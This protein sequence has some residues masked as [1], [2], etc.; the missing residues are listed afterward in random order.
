MTTKKIG[1]VRQHSR[2]GSRTWRDVRARLL[3]MRWAAPLIALVGLAVCGPN[4]KAKKPPT[5]PAKTISGAVLDEANNGIPGASVVLT[6]VEAHKADALYTGAHGAYVFSGLNPN[7]DYQIQA[8]YR[9]LMSEVRHVSSLDSR[10]DVV[11]N[12]VVSSAHPAA[13]HSF[14]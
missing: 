10:P 14:R 2:N 3:R 1:K 11:V 12:L 6:D 7:D 13:S 8:K 5:S 4:L 9:N